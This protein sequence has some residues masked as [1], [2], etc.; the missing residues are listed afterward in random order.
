[1][2]EI[3][4]EIPLKQILTVNGTYDAV[5]LSRSLNIPRQGAAI[6]N[7]NHACS[8]WS[9]DTHSFA[10]AWGESG[11]SLEDIVILTRLSLCGV[12]L[13]DLNNLS[14]ADQR[15]V[16]ELRRLGKLAQSG[17]AA[18]KEHHV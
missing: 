1:M 10:W 8:C 6:K 13:L 17:L 16:V 3:I 7:L 15:N 18:Y 4:S 14:P 12:T 5:M 2:H 11:L 9:V